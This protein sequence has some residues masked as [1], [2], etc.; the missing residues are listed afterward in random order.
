MGVTL[1]RFMKL[2]FFIIPPTQREVYSVH[3]VRPSVFP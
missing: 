2:S 3:G 1:V